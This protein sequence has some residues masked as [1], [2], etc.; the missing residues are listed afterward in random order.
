[1]S[2]TAHFTIEEFLTSEVAAREGIDNTPPESAVWNLM[3]VARALEAVRTVSRGS[4]IITSGYRS[5]ALNA[6]V[7]GA[8]NSAHMLGLAA[9]I[10]SPKCCTPFELAGLIVGND[11]LLCR[12]DQVIYEFGRWVHVAVPP[13]GEDAR[14]EIL[15]IRSAGEGY[16]QGLVP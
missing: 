9:D 2:L 7:G 5:P 6:R 3:R 12:F 8:R 16:L 4:L 15:T 1:M 10:I 14:Q 11:S 13:D